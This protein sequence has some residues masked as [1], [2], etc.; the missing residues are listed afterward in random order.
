M[1]DATEANETEIAAKP[2][3]IAAA[4]GIV[5]VEDGLLRLSAQ[6]DGMIVEI[7]AA[8]GQKV[9]QGDVLA[10]IDS[11]H[12]VIAVHT[13]EAEVRQMQGQLA[14]LKTKLQTQ[15]RQTDRL[16][17]AAAGK[18]VSA[19]VLDE[20]EAQLT[21]TKA[22]VT[23][24]EATL[25]AT[26]SRLEN[27]RLEVEMRTVR[28][29]VDARIVHRSTKV[30]EVISAQNLTELFT[31]LPEGPRIVRAEIQE[32]F[33]K[34]I[35]PGMDVDILAE[36]DDGILVKGRVVR[37]GHVLAQP[38]SRDMPGERVDVRTSDCII[39]IPAKVPLLIGQRVIVRVKP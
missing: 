6:R 4:R 27:I 28:A 1:S 35:K 32:Q 20:A 8:E 26:E 38:K 23:I 11:R 34:L 12:E 2:G 31:L 39:S 10:M 18:A 15:T 24:A 16:R 3:I 21:G 22:E 19:Q 30:G 13:A 5:D 37:I 17:R 7:L 14:M 25:A 29:P 33:V 9:K 36:S